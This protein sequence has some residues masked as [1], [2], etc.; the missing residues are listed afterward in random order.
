MTTPATEPFHHEALLYEGPEGFVDATLP[1][2]FEG[3]AAGE[4]VMVATTSDHLEGLRAELTSAADDIELVD[5]EVLGRN[6]ARIIPAW[7]EF[8]DRAGGPARGIGEPVYPGRGD[9]ELVECQLH[10]AMLNLAFA[11]DDGFRLMCP[12]DV[13]TLDPHV[14]HAAHRTHPFVN[15]E[16]SPHYRLPDAPLSPDEAPLP[17]PPV[18]AAVFGFDR[19]GLRQARELVRSL[20]DDAGLEESR[21]EDLVIAINEVAANTARHGG[22]NGVLRVWE[23]DGGVFCEVRD[24]GRI[25][26]MLVGR[27]IPEPGQL[28]GWGLWIANQVCD[29]V[30]VRTGPSG[31]TVRLFVR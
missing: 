16:A 27:H 13:S 20:A 17:S 5:I 8:I 30:Q 29:L 1:F 14:V 31:S 18:Q 7:R 9:A 22:G 25:D 12:Y 24:R 23:E 19:A 2:I 15:S 21:V 28:G 6:P 26:D 4:P 11:G 10:E 3:L